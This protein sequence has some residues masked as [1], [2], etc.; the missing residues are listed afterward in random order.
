MCRA[1]A[2]G[3][4]RWAVEG[5]G[6]RVSALRRWLGFAPPSDT[7]EDAVVRRRVVTLAWPV[8]IE[9][10]LQTAIGVVDTFFVAKVS[11]EALAGVGTALQLVFIMIVVMSAVSIGASVLV[12]QAVGA[13]EN[14]RAR[15]LAKQSL[16]LGALVTIP[17]SVLGVAFARPAIDLFGVEPAVAEIGASYWRITSLLA[18]GMTGMYVA[19]AV[20]RG[21]GNTKISMQ[22]AILANIINAVAAW[23]LI[24]GNLGFPELGADGSAWAAA[25][26]RIAAFGVMLVVLFRP[27]T[28]ISVRG[29]FGWRP[30]LATVRRVLRIGAPA[31]T[32]ELAFSLSL[33]VLTVL[34]AMLGTQA[35]AA[36]RIAFNALSLAFL[37]GFGVALAAS[38]LVGQSVGA[39]DPRFGRLATNAAGQYATVW[40]S[41]IGV[42]YFL[43]ATPIM[44]AFSDDPA[45]IATGAAALRALAVSQPIWAITMVW[46]GALRGTGNAT[47]PLVVNAIWSWSVIPICWVMITLLDYGLGGVWLVYAITGIAPVIVFRARI[48]RD[49]HLGAAAADLATRSPAANPGPAD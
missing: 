20:L 49:R 18:F 31:A 27:A 1:H 40:M 32:E 3:A 13:G 9:G 37:P 26:G 30:R 6:R 34:V 11:E 2:P 5:S 42:I 4:D 43:A 33:A 44:R 28:I 38:A 35:L 46:A 45:V 7:S 24:F 19:S 21:A 41:L 36:Q 48:N 22:S 25:S 15:G 39:R 29:W 23:L 8:V 16:T 47:F 10:L 17:M 12:A 14:D